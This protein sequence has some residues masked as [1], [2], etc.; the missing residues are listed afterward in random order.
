MFAVKFEKFLSGESN[1]VPLSTDNKEG[2]DCMWYIEDHLKQKQCTPSIC[3]QLWYH[4]FGIS[5][6]SI[7]IV[8]FLKEILYH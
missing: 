6:I 8:V 3:T 2:E 1:A 4:I 7:T 5:I